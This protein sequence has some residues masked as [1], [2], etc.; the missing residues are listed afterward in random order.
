MQLSRGVAGRHENFLHRC[1]SVVACIQQSTAFHTLPFP[2]IHV[3][4]FLPPAT[5][6]R[7]FRFSQFP[8]LHFGR[9]LCRCFLSRSF[10]SRIFSVPTVI[11]DVKASTIRGFQTV[12]YSLSLTFRHQFTEGTLL[13]RFG[14][15]QQF[16][17]IC[18]MPYLL[19]F[20][21]LISV[22]K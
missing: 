9:Y 12:P 13:E 7:C 4:H 11:G 1:L 15:G 3:S 2:N 17:M 20:L 21:S 14:R 10:M 19:S 18:Y 22:C 5:L 16:G 6:C 8:P